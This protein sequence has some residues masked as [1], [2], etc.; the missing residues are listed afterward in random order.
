MPP[1]AAN[2]H[3]ASVGSSLPAQ[4]AYC[5]ASSK[6]TC[7]TGR[8]HDPSSVDPG[9]YG[10]RQL[11]PGVQLHHCERWRVSTGPGVPVKTSEPGTRFSAGAPGKSA[12][13]SGRSATVTYPASSTNS[14]KRAF[15]TG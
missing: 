5:T 15:V 1:R 6:A 7:A 14:A 2:S 9:P 3:S 4:A 8:D 13:S 11:A 12:G 10:C